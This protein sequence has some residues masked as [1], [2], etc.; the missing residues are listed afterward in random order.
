MIAV[1]V[2]KSSGNGLAKSLLPELEHLNDRSNEIE[3]IA[4]DSESQT[5]QSLKSLS[6][7]KDLSGDIYI[8]LGGDGLINLCVQEIKRR[9]TEVKGLLVFPCGTGNDF[10]KCNNQKPFDLQILPDLSKGN[11][12]QKPID[13]GRVKGQSNTT[14]YFGQVLSTGFD[15]LVNE[16]ANRFK[17]IRGKIK[18]TIATLMV[19]MRF[20]PMKYQIEIDGRRISTSAM[21]VSVANGHTYGGGMQIVPHA[22]ND[23][24]FLDLIILAPVSKFELLRVFPKVFKGR[25]V[26][27]PKV[28]FHRGKNIEI[29]IVGEEVHFAYADGERFFPLPISIAIEEKS[30][31]ILQLSNFN[32]R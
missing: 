18:Y 7:D 24:G 2:N 32:E 4:Q 29:D 23:D 28:S 12:S 26:N 25:H 22:E 30:L 10:A 16:R 13:L 21:L 1:V 5:I 31:P 8:A 17:F 14:R 27:H 9:G 6:S 15:S 19:L 3:L 11:Y 20:K